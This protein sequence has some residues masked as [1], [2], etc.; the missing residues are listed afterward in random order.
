MARGRMLS[1]SLGASKKFCATGK[2]PIAI[3]PRASEF[4]QLLYQ[5]LIPHSDDFGRQPGDAFTVKHVV[6]P[7]SPREEPDFEAALQVLETT[8]LIVRYET[9]VGLVLQIVDFDPH[10]SGLKKRTRSKFPEPPGN[11]SN[12]EEFPEDSRNS[13]DVKNG[14]NFTI[15]ES[16]GISSE[17]Q[18]IPPELNRTELNRTGTKDLIYGGADA[19][20]YPRP[21]D[22]LPAKAV[23]PTSHWRR[24]L[25]IAHA[26]IRDFPHDPNN[27]TYETKD[28]LGL[29]HI[30]PRERSPRGNYLF[31]D[32]VE[33]AI[34]QRRESGERDCGRVAK[35]RIG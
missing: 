4:P 17:L 15:S 8:E 28:R 24:A 19:P 2:A 7:T 23:R 35:R 32:A 30:D 34:Q 5:L 12:R 18:E 33:Y 25:G 10:Q 1:K 21:V 13:G 31:Q 20:Q 22:K 11:S 16:A 9:P 14:L 27:W 3:V 29:Q 6:F 26:V